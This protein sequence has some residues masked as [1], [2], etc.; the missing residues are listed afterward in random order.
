MKKWYSVEYRVKGTKA[1]K[2]R[3]FVGRETLKKTRAVVKSIEE[4]YVAE[5]DEPCE[6]RILEHIETV[7]V[8][9][10]IK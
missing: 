7:K 8:I 6:Y 9:E 2:E 1:W 4:E 10:I 5:G 3:Q